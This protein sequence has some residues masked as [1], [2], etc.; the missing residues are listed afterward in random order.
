MPHELCV[1][2]YFIFFRQK[3]NIINKKRDTEIRGT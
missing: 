2:I 1:V 3:G